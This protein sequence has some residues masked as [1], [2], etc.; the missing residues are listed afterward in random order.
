MKNYN[1]P[2]KHLNHDIT[3]V[4]GPFGPHHSKMMCLKCKKFVKWTN[5]IEFNIYKEIRNGTYNKL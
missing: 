4:L 3:I 2:N 1:V 5:S